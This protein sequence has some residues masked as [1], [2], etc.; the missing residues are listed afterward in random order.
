MLIG[1]VRYACR[2]LKGDPGFAMVAVAILAIGIG[3][4]T[5]VF[6]VLNAL[7]LQPL[8]FYAANRLAWIE[9]EFPDSRSGGLSGSTS[10][11]ATLWEWRRQSQSFEQ[12]EAYNAFFGRGSYTLT[13]GNEPE[14][15]VGVEVTQNL[16]PMLGVSPALGR[17]FLK[18]ECLPNGPRAAL[19]SHGLWQRRFASDRRVIGKTV[20][21]ND[22]P[23]II[24][25][26][27]RRDFDFGDVFTPGVKPEI[28]V[29]LILEN[30]QN[31]G[32]TLAVTGRLKPGIS[33]EQ[34]QAELRLI[35]EQ[36]FRSRPEW[37]SWTGAKVTTLRDAVTGRLRPAVLLLAGAAGM[38]L[39]IVCVNIGNLLLARGMSR[40]KE[41]AV[42]AALGAGRGRIIRQML[43]ESLLL[44]GLGGMV[45]TVIAWSGTHAMANLQ[46]VS[47]PLLHTI[48]IDATALGF[49]LLGTL[50]TVL[51]FGLAPAL[52]SSRTDVQQGLKE[53]GRGGGEGKRTNWL[54]G[55]LVISEVALACIL[56]T[57]C[58]LLIRSF[59]RV[60]EVDLGFRPERVAALRI[61]PT[62]KYETSEK[63]LAFMEEAARSIA[64]LPGIEMSSITD[65]LPLDR[66]RSWSLGAKGEVY[67]DKP[68]SAYVRFIFPRYFYT[69]GIPFKAG[70]DF[71]AQDK[72][73]SQNVMIVNETAART[74]W[75]G[76]EAV[77]QVSVI[78]QIE[79][80]IVGVASDV[81][82]SGPEH[83]AGVEVYMPLAQNVSNSV[84][85][86]MRTGMDPADLALSVRAALRPVD[87]DLP[88][89]GF[90]L[91]Q[92]LVD[93]SVSPRRFV[94]T[95]LG[96]FALLALGLASLGI[97]GV[98]SYSVGRRTHEIGIRMALG[99]SAHS[100]Q[101]GVMKSVLLLVSI[102]VATGMAGAM[103]LARLIHSLLYGVSMYDP[104]T[105]AAAP[106][107]LIGVALMASYLPARRAS[108]ID[109]MNALRAA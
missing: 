26:V 71:S 63:R 108:G 98:V 99:A 60:L 69:M 90:R 61:D 46:G 49:M 97:Y 100:V 68:P 52:E 80:Q 82:H 23:V 25:G 109:P 104:L 79:F 47:L 28:V 77:G 40:Q 24:T 42:R 14:R 66:N 67:P 33:P 107:V 92:T 84:D 8:P 51:L 93:R 3:A 54:R 53:G 81:R 103:A 89:T 95:L 21:L 9:N 37:R 30:V 57:G 35:N 76:R 12:I 17:G 83:E 62:A 102:G 5:A 58:G 19:I 18:E 75:P 4:N 65:A 20:R 87:P 50:V 86:V 10:R 74:L 6:S 101:K 38:V 44:G 59:L 64:A 56:L 106:L 105:L 45:G 32:N 48:R 43:T 7:V 55:I 27:M 29:P 88:A 39:L 13:D 16:L 70:R 85:I 72:K 31:W 73:G 22:E 96:G 34:A 41:V 11:V 78:G 1:D 2:N 36:T 15:L 91:L 94:V